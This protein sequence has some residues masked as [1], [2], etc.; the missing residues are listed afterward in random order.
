MVEDLRITTPH[1]TLL[2]QKKTKKKTVLFLSVLTGRESIC[3]RL[4]LAFVVQSRDG[5]W[6]LRQRHQIAEVMGVYISNHHLHNRK[7]E[8]TTTLHCITT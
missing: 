6:V 5:H 1:D 2:Y 8:S 3:E 4:R 7:E